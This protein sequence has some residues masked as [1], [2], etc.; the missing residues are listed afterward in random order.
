MAFQFSTAARNA[1]LDAIE[2]AAG[3]SP[4][5][6]LRS[7]PPPADCAA[8]DA[9]AVLATIPCPADWLASA[10][11]G[12]KVMLGV[13]QDTAADATGAAGHF[14]LKQGSLCHIQG[15]ITV[16]GGGG[17]MTLSNVEITAGQ[18][19]TITGFSIVAGGA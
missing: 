3:G 14:R 17:D 2:A 16:T 1:A 13:W 18:Q 5:L 9:G 7:G 12:A 6:T 8:A 11:S 15:L 19:V 4:V 10:A